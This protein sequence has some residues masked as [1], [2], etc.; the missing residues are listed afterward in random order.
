M[1]LAAW[2]LCAAQAGP[3]TAQELWAGGLRAEAIERLRE[4]IASGADA[5]AR[6]RLVVW[7]LG[8]HRYQA[9]L[10]DARDC[11]SACD[12]LRAEALYHLG[13]YARAVELLSERDPLQVL[14]KVDALEA[15]SRFADSD[16]A[17]A[18]ARAL[19]GE[20][21]PRVLGAE[22]RRLARGGRFEEAAARFRAAVA[23]DPVDGEALFGLGRAL[24]QAGRRE[25]GLAVL[26]R[27]RDLVPLLDAFEFARR[28]VDLAPAHG[29]NWTALAD[30]ERG[31]GRLD[32]AEQA[33]RR[34]AELCSGEDRVPNALRWARLMAQDRGDVQAA[35]DLLLRTAAATR[36]VRLHVRA[37]DLLLSARRAGEAAAQY[38]RALALRP[39]D[40][41]I[42]E[43]LA[44]ARR[45]AEAPR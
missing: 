6:R 43:R 11:G 28:G 8:V 19:V 37:G 21:D 9:A 3:R 33:Y 27:H 24:V 35:V 17:L 31:L 22:G 25:E 7:Q 30:A 38:E 4:E 12:A 16:A 5:D 20:D 10:A 40:A 29:P 39:D 15:L 23:R 14:W 36:D 2:A 42:Q 1:I 26:Q 44:R 13:E 18:R 34:A 41:E 32:R 45:A